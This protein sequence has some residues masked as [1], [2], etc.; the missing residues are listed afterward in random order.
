M[1]DTCHAGC[2]RAYHL[3]ITVFDALL[4]SRDLNLPIA[5]FVTMVPQNDE[6]VKRLGNLNRPIRFSDPG[7]EDTYFYIGLKRV[8]SRLFPGTV[9]C[10]F[11]QEW[12]R[13]EPVAA[14]GNHPGA[15][16]AGRCGIY[17]SRPLM[18]RAYPSHLHPN[19][20]LG[21]IGNPKPAELVKT[22]AIYN[23][24][25]DKWDAASFGS[26]PTQVVHNLVLNRYEVEFQNKLIEEWNANPRPLRDF[27]P[28]AVACYA[29]RFRLAPEM[30]QTPP[31]AEPAP[32]PVPEL[33]PAP[34]PE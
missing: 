8:E 6:G 32:Q 28:F 11:L 33:E 23:L 10:F 30:V 17:G 2:C 18:C 25:P 15:T 7:F 19:G 20:A 26:D 12:H 1:C 34:I 22:N 4:I 14:R 31:A 9:K 16:V 24:C 3:F 27:F 13:A 21:L 29:N 5:E